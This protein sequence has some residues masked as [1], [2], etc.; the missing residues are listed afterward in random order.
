[1]LEAVQGYLREFP[2][3]PHLGRVKFFEGDALFCQ[4]RRDAAIAAFKVAR[5]LDAAHAEV[6][7]FAIVDSYCFEKDY[8]KARE[9]LEKIPKTRMNEGRWDAFQRRIEAGRAE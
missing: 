5:D 8:A 3:G 9:E 6:I 7:S 1:M 2:N 4:G